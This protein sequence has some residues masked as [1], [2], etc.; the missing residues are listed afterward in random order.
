MKLDHDGD[1]APAEQSA[2]RGDMTQTIKRCSMLRSDSS[3]STSTTVPNVAE[4]H[5]DERLLSLG[6]E[7]ARLERQYLA[8]V[9]PFNLL[10]DRAQ[11]LASK[12]AGVSDPPR[13]YAET[14]LQL[15]K[16]KEAEAKVGGIDEADEIVTALSNQMGAIIDEIWENAPRTLDG[17]R[18]YARV[19]K[20]FNEKLWGGEFRT[21]DFEEQTIRA[22]T[23]ALLGMVAF[24]KPMRFKISHV[25][26]VRT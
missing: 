25:E 23:D 3:F 24:K 6:E 8:A 20:H 15:E 13:G 17:M 1:A 18:V 12:L 5:L 26:T 14:N 19:L 7:F 9:Q 10:C 11:A 4:H 2:A 16:M 21:L 22:L